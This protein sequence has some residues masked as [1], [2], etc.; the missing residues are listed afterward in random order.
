MTNKEILN[1][2]SILESVLYYR[3]DGSDDREN[4]SYTDLETAHNA[5]NE[6]LKFW[7]RVTGETL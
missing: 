1:N 6:L 2:I 3:L 7:H 5:A 4:V